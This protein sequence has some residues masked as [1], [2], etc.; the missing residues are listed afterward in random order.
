[1]GWCTVQDFQTDDLWPT[2]DGQQ[3]SGSIK[4]K[5]HVQ[6]RCQVVLQDSA[7]G[8][9]NSFQETT[10][11]FFSNFSGKIP[12]Y[13]YK[14]IKSLYR[15]FICEIIFKKPTSNNS[16]V[17]RVMHLK[18]STSTG[19]FHYQLL[20]YFV[21]FGQFE[22]KFVFK[23]YKKVVLFI[24]CWISKQLWCCTSQKH[25]FELS[26]LNFFCIEKLVCNETFSLH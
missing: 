2:D 17:C 26:H 25:W 24:Y 15:Y 22:Q 13:L 21:Y 7:S 4:E 18:T 19:Q 12:K 20:E 23:L 1:M 5:V 3:K 14:I 6:G 9:G 11:R 8:S 10:K 16:L